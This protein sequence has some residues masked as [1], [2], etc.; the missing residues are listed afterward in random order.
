M[1]NN[2][3]GAKLSSR[4]DSFTGSRPKI[5]SSG[6]STSY[7]NDKSATTTPKRQNSMKSAFGKSGSP[8]NATPAQ[9]NAHYMLTGAYGEQ[10]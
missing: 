8:I 1:E 3:P 6:T 10:V 9:F 7:A 2:Y 5:G 4:S